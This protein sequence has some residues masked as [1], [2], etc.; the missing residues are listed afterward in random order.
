MPQK[1]LKA[2]AVAKSPAIRGDASDIN[3]TS[4]PKPAS[5][6]W[7]PHNGPQMSTA[8]KV[9]LPRAP[10][11]MSRRFFQIATA[12]WAEACDGES[13]I[14]LEFAVLSELQ[15]VPETDQIGLA[16]VVGVDRTNIGLIIDGLEKRGLV[17][18]SVNP[19]DRRARLIRVTESGVQAHA[20]QARKTTVARE[21]I[22]APLTA[23]ERE[24]LYDLL[25]RIIAANE[26]YSIPGAGRRKR[27]G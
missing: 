8:T 26:Q 7:L 12:I 19:R 21:K 20:S 6:P 22:L 9:P 2:T 23:E 18:R 3:G 1:P 10:V 11:P 17:E 4:R 15:R 27:S 24:T 5:W 25:E 13:L 16:A 14:H